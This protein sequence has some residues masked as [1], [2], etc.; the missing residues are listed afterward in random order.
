MRDVEEIKNMTEKDV[1]ENMLE[2]A[3]WLSI[4]DDGSNDI[5]IKVKNLN[6]HF[7]AWQDAERE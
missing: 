5:E 2:L 7:E 6:M 4:Q 1:L 3:L